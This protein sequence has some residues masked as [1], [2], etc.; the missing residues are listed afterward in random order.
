[1]PIP[2][3]SA[4][5]CLINRSVSVISVNR[6][7]LHKL[8]SNY[9]LNLQ[10]IN[11]KKRKENENIIQR[12]SVKYYYYIEV[13]FNP[14]DVVDQLNSIFVKGY[15]CTNAKSNSAFLFRYVNDE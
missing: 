6:K 3:D 12:I 14:N 9:I 10:Q 13:Q 7:T 15:I 8:N 2:I 1:M 5:V 11:E 4:I